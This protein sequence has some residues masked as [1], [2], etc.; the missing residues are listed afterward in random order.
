MLNKPMARREA[1]ESAYVQAG[2]TCSPVDRMAT[3]FREMNRRTGTTLDAIVRFSCARIVASAKPP[4][5]L[6]KA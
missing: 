1:M 5:E 3:A 4:R 6:R 2:V